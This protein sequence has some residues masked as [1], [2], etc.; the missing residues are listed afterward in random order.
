MS[1]RMEWNEIRRAKETAS[2][3]VRKLTRT[4]KKK[5]V[6]LSQEEVNEA[7]ASARKYIIHVHFG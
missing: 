1:D 3:A 2:A 6:T 4:L 7:K 5:G